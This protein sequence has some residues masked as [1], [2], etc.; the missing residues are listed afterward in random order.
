MKEFTEKY[1]ESGKFGNYLV[2]N[3]FKAVKKLILKIRNIFQTR[4][5]LLHGQQQNIFERK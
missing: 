3:Y 2:S 4:H 1:T 5:R